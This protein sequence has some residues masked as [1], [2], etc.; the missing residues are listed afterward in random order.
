MY[1]V[2]N[3][4]SKNKPIIKKI[5]PLLENTSEI[6]SSFFILLFSSSSIFC[7]S[8]NKDV[9]I[10]LDLLF[11]NKYF[12]NITTPNSINIKANILIISPT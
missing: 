4:K 3:I 10:L 2:I 8:S 7:I 9:S 11:L 5:L 12:N 6:L 1:I